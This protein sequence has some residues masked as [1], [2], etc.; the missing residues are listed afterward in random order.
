MLRSLWL[1][2]VYASFLG[3]GMSA[4]FVLSLGYVWVDTFRPQDVAYILL[5]QFPVALVIGGAAIG[6]YIAMDRRN[7]PPP[8]LI[9]ILHVA[10]A[11]WVTLTLI[12]AAATAPI[13]AWWTAIR[14]WR[15][16][17]CC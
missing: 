6:A 17:A 15:K 13:W 16:A 14:G 7:P 10:M 8:N 4:P 5:N 1:L 11:I 12:W 3:I 9:S 2:F